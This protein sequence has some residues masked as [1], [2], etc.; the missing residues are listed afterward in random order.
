MSVNKEANK[1]GINSELSLEE[2]YRYL[3]I[4]QLLC[5]F[6]DSSW[7]AAKSNPNISGIIECVG[8]R[9]QYI[10]GDETRM[11]LSRDPNKLNIVL[12]IINKNVNNIDNLDLLS[13]IIEALYRSYILP[14]FVYARYAVRI[15]SNP[16]GYSNLENLIA[17]FDKDT[18]Y[19]FFDKVY[20]YL[21]PTEQKVKQEIR[22]DDNN[23]VLPLKFK[24]GDIDKDSLLDTIKLFSLLYTFY[25]N[26]ALNIKREKLEEYLGKVVDIADSL[27]IRSDQ[28][29][30]KDFINMITPL[31]ACVDRIFIL[32]EIDN[33][34]AKSVI[35][36]VY[37]SVVNKSQPDEETTYKIPVL[38]SITTHGKIELNEDIEAAF[39]TKT[40]TMST[41]SL[42]LKSLRALSKEAEREDIDRFKEILVAIYGKCI[43]NVIEGKMEK[44]TL[45]LYL[46]NFKKLLD[47]I[48]DEGSQ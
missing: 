18:T 29:S 11:D 35:A 32:G 42:L 1:E 5:G 6:D 22:S 2:L 31:S 34:G 3:N 12:D 46:K 37:E 24:V 10:I 33:N 30:F 16:K 36:K 19:E 25:K 43:N 39:N 26:S 48:E 41:L 14:P 17:A 4:K 20:G 27:L 44:D 47:K 40:I 21:N 45:D 28:V 23:D 7:S 9:F 38:G 8:P 15:A 13:K